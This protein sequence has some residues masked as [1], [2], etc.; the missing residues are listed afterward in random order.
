[1]GELIAVFK[2]MPQG[3]ETDLETLEATVRKTVPEGVT[4]ENVEVKPVAFGLKSLN[5]T[6]RMEDS[7]DLSIDGLETAL[8][9]ID[10]VESVQ[11]V[12]VGRL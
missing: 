2:I 3:V 7:E 1:M 6:M 4:V 12:D 8:S 5:V 10:G 9:E 11:V